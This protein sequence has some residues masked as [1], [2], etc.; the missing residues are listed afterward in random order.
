MFSASVFRAVAAFSLRILTVSALLTTACTDNGSDRS[1]T[2]PGGKAD[3]L[4]CA[5]EPV[6][7]LVPALGGFRFD[8]PMLMVRH[9]TVA[10]RSYVAERK[11][12]IWHADEKAAPTPKI[13]VALDIS[14]RVDAASA[15]IGILG[16]AVHPKF[17]TNRFAFVAYTARD[18]HAELEL[19][20]SRFKAKTGLKAF[21]P[22]SELVILRVPQP[23]ENH[24]GGHLA[25]GP[26][27]LLYIALG[28]GG[29]A[30]DP[31]NRAQDVDDL[32]GKIL[33][34]DVDKP[35]YAIPSDNPFA[36]SGGRG[37]IYAWGFQDPRRLSFDRETGA[38]WVAD[39]GAGHGHQELDRVVS[40]GNYGWRV[41][42]GAHCFSPDT[43]CNSDE[44][45]DPE[46]EYVEPGAAITGGFVYR[47]KRLPELDGD[48]IF[49]DLAS[50]EI[51][52]FDTEAAD[53]EPRTLLASDRRIASFTQLADGELLAVDREQGGIYSLAMT[54][55]TSSEIRF[56]EVYKAT[57][58][59]QC[60]PCHT[61][62]DSGGLDLQ[63]ADV[64]FGELVGQ[65]SQTEDCEGRDLVVPG[66]PEESL[67][68]QKV[69]EV[70]LCGPAM[71]MTEPLTAEEI[72]LIRDWIAGGALR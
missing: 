2:G 45:I 24:K 59:N 64:A 50:G 16:F 27:K 11:G 36:T 65:K 69:A 22:A 54:C 18:E 17:T 19:R 13:T 8:E 52:A 9:P 38:L 1:S 48:L 5:S 7:G 26:D 15:Q 23:F 57:M 56:D 47:G 61:A 49:A 67:L 62:I 43:G 34:V 3:D 44:L 68:Y 70:N 6:L 51:S 33:R 40:G 4:N 46:A 30:G 10:T 25:F 14:A 32:R 41:R 21:D 72:A 37:E 63:S 39:V 66:N 60:D 42:E 58:K 71:P 29:S 28:D 53:A 31:E 12:V 55:E 20:V 35:P